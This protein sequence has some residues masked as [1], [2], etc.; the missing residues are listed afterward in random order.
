[1]LFMNKMLFKFFL[2]L[3]FTFSMSLNAWSEI[4]QWT[5][6]KGQTHFGD[7]APSKIAAKEI[8]SQ[9]DKINTTSDLTQAAS[10]DSKRS[11]CLCG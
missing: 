11:G 6:D 8:S 7:R 1:M 2:G 5:D 9:V 3:V 4:Y 10:K